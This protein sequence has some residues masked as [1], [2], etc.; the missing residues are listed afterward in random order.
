MRARAVATLLEFERHVVPAVDALRELRGRRHDTGRADGAPAVSAEEIHRA[1]DAVVTA[2]EK[3]R[4][5]MPEAQIA[6]TRREL[7]AWQEA[8]CEGVPHF[9]GTRDAVPAPEDGEAAAFVGPVTLPN[10]DRHDVHIEAFSVVREDPESTPRL[11]ADY[12]HPKAVFQSTRLLSAS[13]G[14]R[15]GNCVVFFPENIPAATRCTDQNF[16]WFFFNRHTEIYAQTL[17]ITERLCGPGSP[18]AGETALVSADVDPETTYQARCVWGYMHDYFHHTGPRP[19]DRH[20]A[21]KTTWRPGLLEELKVDMKSAIACFEEDVPHGPLVFEYIILERLFRYPAQPEP[22]RNFDAGTG[23][24]LG[25][26]LAS[27]GLFTQDGQGR[28][29]LGPKADIVES[30]RELVGLIEEI[31]RNEDD[32]V[33]KAGAVDFLFGTLLRRPEAKPDRYGGPLAPLALWGDEVR[34]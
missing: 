23:F 31:E 28:R 3:L 17:A 21:V 22:L 20:L 10:S 8:G 1:V 5:L 6:S 16:A 18:F 7:R 30:V 15:E 27:K 12:P 24:A 25:T 14:L 34:V 2:V 19:L 13:R 26:W 11:Q 29:A 33:Y 4:G 32:A 9:D